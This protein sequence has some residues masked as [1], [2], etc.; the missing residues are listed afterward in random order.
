[1]AQSILLSIG[2]EKTRWLLKKIK[3]LYHI[4][5]RRSRPCQSRPPW[6]FYCK[7]RSLC[8]AESTQRDR[9]NGMERGK[10]ATPLFGSW[11]QGHLIP[12]TLKAG[13]IAP[14]P[15]RPFVVC[16]TVV[17]W[18]ESVWVVGS[19]LSRAPAVCTHQQLHLIFCSGTDGRLNE[20]VIKARR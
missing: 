2:T 7:S 15:S 6:S 14:R 18:S 5:W 12:R 13:Q 17:P 9:F 1:M 20:S 10:A 11:G 4:Q 16:C 8:G 3:S 19:D